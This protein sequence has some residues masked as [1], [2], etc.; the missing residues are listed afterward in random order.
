[1]N[2]PSIDI[3]EPSAADAEAVARLAWRSFHEAFADHP[4][5]HPDDMKVYMEHAFAPETIASE[6]ADPR[7]TYLV[8]EI[9]GEMVGYGKVTRGPAEECV[10]GRRP[11]EIARLYCLETHIGKGIGRRLMEECLSIAVRERCDVVWL[12]V[13]EF[14]Y[15]AQEFYRR[16]GFEKCGTHVFLLGSDPQTDWVMQM[17]LTEE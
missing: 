9:G 12:G 7:N 17:R 4:A 16:A 3:R 14:N 5:N 15:R 10:E 13:W 8:A 2:D 11:L 6:I 1:M